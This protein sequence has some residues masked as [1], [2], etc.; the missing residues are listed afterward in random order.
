MSGPFITRNG[1][2]IS[3]GLAVNTNKYG[4]AG[5]SLRNSFQL[6]RGQ[7]TAVY[8]VTENNASEIPQIVTMYDV[9]CVWPNG[10]HDIIPC[11]AVQP[12]F[13]GGFNNFMEVLPNDPG[14]SAN[15]GT[16][17]EHLKRGTMVLVGFIAGQKKAGVIIGAIPHT[18]PRA[19][20]TR[21][22]KELGSYLEGEF[23]GLNFKITNEGA[24]EVSFNGPR[25]DDGAPISTNGPTTFEIDRNGSVLL[26]TNQEQTISVDRVNKTVTVINGQTSYTMDQNGS[27]VTIN[28]KDLSINTS[29]DVNVT[30]QG[31]ANVKA[32][33]DVT[34]ASGSKI[35][36][37]H[38]GAASEPFVLGNK[39]K[40]FMNKLITEIAKIQH[41]GNL[42]I[43][44]SPP[45][46]AAAISALSAEL[47][48][49]LSEL[50]SGEK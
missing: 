18:N 15:S 48:S 27:K 24:L 44:T 49:L 50:I 16:V 39:F 6:L 41:V 33:S 20:A 4:D 22:K 32:Q 46:T 45:I 10:H 29:N 12:L 11:I 42:G 2:V 26:K 35:N 19:V 34:I 28:C 47:D 5:V 7:I 36:L 13:G 17:P 1:D 38:G 21:P 14:P 30:A 8:P 25:D 3:S 43:P 9:R 40:T 23:Q 37:S 31:K